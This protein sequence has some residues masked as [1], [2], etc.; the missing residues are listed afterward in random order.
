MRKSRKMKRSAEIPPRFFQGPWPSVR[1]YSWRYRIALSGVFPER[2]ID[3]PAKTMTIRVAS[4]SLPG[5]PLTWTSLGVPIRRAAVAPASVETDRM[6]D[7][8]WSTGSL[9]VTGGLVRGALLRGALARARE[10][11]H[12]TARERW[13]PVVDAHD[14]FEAREQ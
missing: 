4:Y 11:A 14:A 8:V 13:G 6:A 7:V 12:R 2:H 1:D 10:R 5:T 3:L 9:G